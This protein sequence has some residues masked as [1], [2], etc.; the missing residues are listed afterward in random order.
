MLAGVWRLAV[1]AGGRR[2]LEWPERGRSPRPGEALQGDERTELEGFREGGDPFQLANDCTGG[3]ESP[4]VIVI[5]P[6]GIG[7]RD[8]KV[9]P[10]LSRQLVRASRAFKVVEGVRV[11]GQRMTG[12]EPRKQERRA[13]V[14][15][16]QEATSAQAERSAHRVE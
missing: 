1:R 6:A 13:K 7:K 3:V 16:T 4:A 9:R 11:Q 5:S 12:Q 15:R 10:G 2:Y 8:G 14:A